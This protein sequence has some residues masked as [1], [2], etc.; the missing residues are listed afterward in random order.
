MFYLNIQDA[1]IIHDEILE[2]TKG[3]KGY[4]KVNIGYLSSALE[5]IKDDVYYPT[6][7]DKLTHLMFACIKFH[8]FNDANKRSAIY[9]GMHLLSINDYSIENFAKELE[10]VVVKVASNHLSK[11]ELKEILKNYLS[12]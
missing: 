7:C 4:N 8:P 1:I 5:Q 11:I 6:F 9:L 3:L 10:E 12:K 2:Q